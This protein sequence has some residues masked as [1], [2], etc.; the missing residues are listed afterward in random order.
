MDFP[1]TFEGFKNWEFFAGLEKYFSQ[2][3]IMYLGVVGY[4]NSFY[5]IGDF[6]QN[7]E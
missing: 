5:V 7:Q 6:I 2:D 3:K 1:G 4:N